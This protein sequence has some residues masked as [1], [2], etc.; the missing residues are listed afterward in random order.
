MKKLMALCVI[1]NMIFLTGCHRI[2]DLPIG[3][4]EPIAINTIES[5]G[6]YSYEMTKNDYNV[7]ETDAVKIASNESIEG[8]Y[9]YDDGKL[10]I[11]AAGDYIL[12][13][14]LGNVN[15]IISV[16]D[17][18][19]VH[20]FLDN[21]EINSDS[22]PAIYVENANKVIITS[23]EGTK[24]IISDG[25]GY[26]EIH[27]ACIFSNSDLTINGEGIL[28][29]YG[30]YADG[31][32]TKDRMKLVNTNLFVKAKEDGIRGNDAVILLDSTAEVECEGTGILSNSDDDMVIV[33]GGS[34]KVIAGQNAFFSNRYISIH[35]C[36]TD[37]YSIWE[38]MKCNGVIDIGE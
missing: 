28:Y 10:T 4:Q 16:F 36:L 2:L 33:Q 27:K 19:I 18:E 12:E 1:V 32:R 35:D 38:T 14:N 30:Y 8:I 3:T 15:L 25:S 24:N 34:C 13:G 9:G 5:G 20:L 31:V 6:E 7:L 11:Y 22:G 26:E 23:K 17:D 21:V 37:L 29:V